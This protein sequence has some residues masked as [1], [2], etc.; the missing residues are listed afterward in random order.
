MSDDEQGDAGSDQVTALLLRWQGGDREALDE[1]MPMVHARLLR[2]VARELRRNRLEHTLDPDAV[3]NDIYLSLKFLDQRLASWRSSGAFLAD[4]VVIIRRLLRDHVRGQRAAESG[5][6][7]HLPDE[8][9]DA[10][11]EKPDDFWVL[12]RDDGYAAPG[13]VQDLG[14]AQARNLAASLASLRQSQIEAAHRLGITLPSEERA[15]HR[16]S[17]PEPG[18]QYGTSLPS[19]EPHGNQ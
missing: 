16:Q 3:I 14:A 19:E 18:P 11:V 1:L 5:S 17:E 15:S 7:L 2:L 9:V 4:A 13:K 12:W 8:E 10:G 6:A